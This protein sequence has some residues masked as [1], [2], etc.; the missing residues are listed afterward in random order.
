M[1]EENP[2]PPLADYGYIAD[3]H[4]AALISRTGSIDW[5]CLPRYDSASC[6][7]RL[8][9]WNK[10]GFCSIQPRGRYQMSRRYLPDTL[11]LETMFENDDGKVRLLDCMATREGGHRHPHRQILRTLE[12][13][14]GSMRFLIDVAPAFDYGS[15]L[16][17]IQKRG[18]HFIALG[19]SNGLLISSDH[20]LKM[21]HRHQICGE[22]I[23]E[24]NRRA[25]L[26]ILWRQPEDLDANLVEPP[27]VDELDQRLEGTVKWWERWTR[28]RVWYVL[29]L[30]SSAFLIPFWIYSRVMNGAP[31]LYAELLTILPPIATII[32]LYWMRW[33]AFRSPRTWF[34]QIGDRK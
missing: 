9:D 18:D 7:G 1:S 3:C 16:P 23:L 32:G 13:I 25:R 17:W 33:W 4:S 20:P 8:L 19:S 11:V 14:R 21:K 12:G 29:L 34:D 5:C 27:P 15:V 6:F 28:Q 30:L 31:P 10:G 24:K 2:Y 26:S 22:W